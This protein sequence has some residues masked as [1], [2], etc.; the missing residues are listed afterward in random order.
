M[1]SVVLRILS[2]LVVLNDSPQSHREH[3]VKN[4]ACCNHLLYTCLMEPLRCI[5]SFHQVV[6]TLSSGFFTLI[7]GLAEQ[8]LNFIPVV[9]LN[10]D[11]SIL[12][13]STGTNFTL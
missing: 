3:K 9:T 6:K 12:G 2:A 11:F 10:N 4:V 13:I 5:D 1:I 8:I 7:P